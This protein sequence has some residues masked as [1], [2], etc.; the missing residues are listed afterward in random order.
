MTELR[1]ALPGFCSQQ[2]QRWDFIS[3]PLCLD[4][5]WDPPSLLSSEYRGLFP[6]G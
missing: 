6:V 3:S 2:V 1:V 4:R 5:L